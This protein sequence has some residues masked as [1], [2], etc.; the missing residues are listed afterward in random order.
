MTV[1][2]GQ[3]SSLLLLLDAISIIPSFQVKVFLGNGNGNGNGNDSL[4]RCG[5]IRPSP[6]FSVNKSPIATACHPAYRSCLLQAE[7]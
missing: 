1:L 6:L 5:R 7:V 2:K 3:Q 4:E